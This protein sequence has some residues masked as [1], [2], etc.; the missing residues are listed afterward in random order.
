MYTILKRHEVPVEMTWKTE[1]LFE[2]K[3]AFLEGLEDL[4]KKTHALKTYKGRLT[5]S[6]STLYEAILA[7]E[8]LSILA[9]SLDS[10]TSLNQA[11]DASNT[12][13]QELEMQFS[14]AATKMSADI[15]FFANE[16]M[17]M[18]ASTCDQYFK[19]EA[20]LEDYRV[21][22][23]DL[24]DQKQ[25][26][27]SDDTEEALAALGEVTGAPYGIYSISKAAD[28]VFDS[29][30]DGEGQSLP[31]SFNLFEGKYE[32]SDDPVIRKNA[33][34]SFNKTLKQY[35]NTYA[36]IY[37]TEVKKQVALS[38]LRGY[39]SVT[40]ML[41][42]PQKVTEEMYHRQID[43]IYKELAPHMRKYAGLLKKQLGLDTLH[44]YDL[45]APLDNTYNP[46]ATF[47]EAKE[48]IL[49][50]LAV[51]G[52]DY[53][54]IIEKAFDDR[55]IDYADNVGKGSGAFCDIPYGAHPYIFMTFQNNMRDA[56][57]LTHE[58]GH[59]GHFYLANKTQNYFNTEPSMFTVEAPST[60]NEMLL[61][62]YLL[63]NNDDPQMKKWVIL[64]F[65]GTYYHNF[66]THLLEAAYQRQVYDYAE[67][68]QPITADLL[69]N[70]KLEVLR[71]F[72]GDSVEIDDDAG[73]T[74]MRQPHYYMGLYPYTY[75]AGLTAS[76]ACSAMIFEQGQ[77][78]VDKWIEMLKSGGRLTPLEL[79]KVAGMD[80]TTDAPV[81]KAID[82][83]GSLIDQLIELS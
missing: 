33:Y 32:Y 11:V 3:E 29:I 21:Y 1:D 54:K 75:S 36:A 25:Y 44:F 4:V 79:L 58:L 17:T 64:Q 82:Y 16:I 55:W 62:R 59:A 72:W 74:W 2:N 61:G 23:S 15:T 22:I 51:M 31:N 50:S 9:Y 6:A 48:V 34:A 40:Q 65:M 38:K 35:K 68:G 76:T 41:L 49:K 69:T 70:T 67:K 8:D 26:K 39:E 52:D 18:S 63:Q 28:M 43:I 37:S 56:F 53:V 27:L 47:E 81:K 19:E 13:S 10:Y 42:Q 60:M 71:G 73:L 45:K 24:Q 12:E 14:S 83:V 78:A 80:F 46:S 57:T 20:K 77:V 7:L 5:E 30:E 66:V